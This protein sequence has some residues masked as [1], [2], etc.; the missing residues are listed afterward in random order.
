MR[1]EKKILIALSILGAVLV[2]VSVVIYMP[3]KDILTVSIMFL[4]KIIT[5]SA[6]LALL[7]LFL[8]LLARTHLKTAQRQERQEAREKARQ[9]RI[10]NFAEKFKNFASKITRKNPQHRPRIDDDEAVRLIEESRLSYRQAF[11]TLF[12]PE[13]DKKKE[14]ERENYFQTKWRTRVSKKVN[15]RIKNLTQDN[16]NM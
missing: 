16:L 10:Q 2:C 5:S 4:W 1:K 15:K 11:D 13:Q 14:Q 7:G 8:V 12:P 9:E 6:G 3:L